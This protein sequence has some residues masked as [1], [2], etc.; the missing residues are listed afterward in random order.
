MYLRPPSDILHK[1]K[2]ASLWAPATDLC[3][4]GA[5]RPKVDRIWPKWPRSPAMLWFAA[6]LARRTGE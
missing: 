5:T 4:S 1:K 3:I 6:V 2:P